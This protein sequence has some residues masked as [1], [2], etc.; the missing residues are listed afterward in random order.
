M[1]RMLTVP[2]DYFENDSAQSVSNSVGLCKLF[3]PAADQGVVDAAVYGFMGKAR[4]ETVLLAPNRNSV[5]AGL[6]V[7]IRPTFAV[8]EI[9]KEITYCFIPVFGVITVNNVLLVSA[10]TLAHE[11]QAERI[12]FRKRFTDSVYLLQR[13][14]VADRFLCRLGFSPLTLQRLCRGKVTATAKKADK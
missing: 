10:K 8:K 6:F 9:E 5:Y 7:N 2:G 13:W 3:D 4:R 11:D 1:Q 14:R 12:S